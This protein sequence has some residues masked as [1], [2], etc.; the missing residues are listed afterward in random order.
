[1]TRRDLS[2]LSPTRREM[3]A[4]AAHVGLITRTPAE[5]LVTRR[6]EAE[7]WNGPARKTR[8]YDSEAALLEDMRR[9]FGPPEPNASERP[10]APRQP[11]RPDRQHHA[12]QHPETKD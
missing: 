8:Q 3:E 2:I 6:W 4:H 9:T 11:R 7:W 5:S 10:A 1:M 12:P